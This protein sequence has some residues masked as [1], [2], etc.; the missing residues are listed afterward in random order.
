MT[1]YVSSVLRIE[2]FC[3]C[4]TQKF[5]QKLPISFATFT[6]FDSVLDIRTILMPRL[7]SSKAYWR[8]MPSVQPVITKKRLSFEFK[9]YLI[10]RH[11]SVKF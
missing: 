3:E 8:P 5:K 2:E 9:T 1:L 6:N 11:G 4:E 10:L 7:A